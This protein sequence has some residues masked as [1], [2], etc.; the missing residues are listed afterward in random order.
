MS[1]KS[2]QPDP[3]CRQWWFETYKLHAELA[4]RVAS[5][6]EGMNK[7]YSGMVS[8]IVAASVV[9]HRIAPDAGTVWV[10]AVLGIVVSLSWLLSVWS[11]SGR[12]SAKGE[13]LRAMEAKLPFQ[14]LIEEKRR[15]DNQWSLRRKWSLS[16]IPWLFLA[17][18]VLWLFVL[19][20]ELA[21]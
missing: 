21:D 8:G 17:L 7:L 20:Q 14:F 19:C 11:V 6:R 15:F 3:D 4:E 2:S 10:L 13:T 18:C 5:L 16:I 12:L 9:L 1:E